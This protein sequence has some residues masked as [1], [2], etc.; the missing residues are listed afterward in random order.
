[1]N[2]LNSNFEDDQA[3][4]TVSYRTTAKQEKPVREQRGGFGRRR[5]TSPVQFNGI[6][7]R[8]RKKIRW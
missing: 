1:M 6:H 5:G 3:S 7:R 2:Y 8:R 4:F